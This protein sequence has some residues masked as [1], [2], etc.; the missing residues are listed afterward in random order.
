MSFK[1]IV[2]TCAVLASLA[3]IYWPKASSSEVLAPESSPTPI[4]TRYDLLE[5]FNSYRLD[6]NLPALTQDNTLCLFADLRAV[7][8]K[9][10]FTH[11]G[12]WN[13]AEKLVTKE[14]Q[15]V[16]LGENLAVNYRTT[17]G[18]ME[19]W[20]ASPTHRE[21]LQRKEFNRVCFAVDGVY[22]VQILGEAETGGKIHGPA[23]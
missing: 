10:S 8:V 2:I 21:N 15:Y 3:I 4:I 14:G 6:R 1:G 20:N 5:E 7:E 22:I 9:N 17:K 18:V 12:F 11:D 19:A 23:F 16:G 13:K